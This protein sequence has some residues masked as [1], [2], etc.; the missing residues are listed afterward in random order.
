[1]KFTPYK[2]F[3]ELSMDSRV[4]VV[5]IGLFSCLLWTAICGIMNAFLI[6]GSKSKVS[7]VDTI[8]KEYVIDGKTYKLEQKV[9]L[10]DG[11]LS[12][13]TEGDQ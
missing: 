13:V 6:D 4:F 9:K 8:T 10:V 11:K 5:F 2:K 12:V 7:D 3:M 1:M